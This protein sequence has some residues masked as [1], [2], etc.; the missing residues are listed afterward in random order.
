ML[1]FAI[2]PILLGVIMLNVVMLIVVASVGTIK[3][4]HKLVDAAP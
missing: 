2:K 3:G 1:S 4:R